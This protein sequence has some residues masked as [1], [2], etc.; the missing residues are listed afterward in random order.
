MPTPDGHHLA[1]R[2]EIPQ[3]RPHMQA[4]AE[5]RGVFRDMEL[6]RGGLRQAD[7]IMAGHLLEIDLPAGR[8]R[9]AP[10][11]HQHQPVLAEHEALDIVGQRVLGGKT[12][13]G[14]AGRNRRGNVDAFAFLDVDIDVGILAQERGERLRQM[15]GKADGVGE[16]MDAGAHAACEP[17]E[18]AAHRLHIVDHEPRV[19]EQAFAGRREFDAAAAA[20]QKQRRRTPPP[21]P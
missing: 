13:F 21:G 17:R 16:Q 19:I 9:A 3:A 6:Q 5:P 10:R 2:I 1:D 14:G 12:E 20:L 11:R 7:E 8:E 15:L 4:Q 18:V